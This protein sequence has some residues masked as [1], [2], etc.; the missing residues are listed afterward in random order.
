MN[1]QVQPAIVHTVAIATA[2]IAPDDER[3]RCLRATMET[4][5]ARRNPATA[6]EVTDERNTKLNRPPRGH[7]QYLSWFPASAGLTD[8]TAN[9]FDS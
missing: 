4:I 8:M 3:A 6:L 1:A 2:A 5:D 9:A 7:L